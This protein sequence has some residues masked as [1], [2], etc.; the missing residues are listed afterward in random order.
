MSDIRPR[1]HGWHAA[2][3][4]GATAS[5]LCAI[6]CA[7]LPFVLALL[8]LVGLGFLAGHAFERGFVLFAATL[9]SVAFVHGY[10]C[11]RRRWP[12]ALALPGLV[13]LVA[14][15]CVDIDVAVT[16]HT[17]MV[18]I[19]G[20]L[21]ACAHLVNLRLSR[22]PRGPARRHVSTLPHRLLP[23]AGSASVAVPPGRPATMLTG[24]HDGQG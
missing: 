1:R 6:H 22:N 14:G 21:V 8:P 20:S 12:L 3:R 10:R 13:L 2:D 15:V 4:V 5:L 16:A 18:V 17:V 19:G 9:A 11:H 24:G 7:A 23:C